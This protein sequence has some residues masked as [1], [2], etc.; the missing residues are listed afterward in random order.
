MSAAKPFSAESTRREFLKTGTL[1]GASLV[2][3]FHL[4]ARIAQ[5]ATGANGK[6]SARGDF[7][8]NAFIE[9]KPS[10]E[11]SLTVA[12]S[13]MGQGVRTSLAMILA[14]ELDAD[15]ARVTVK[16]AD[17]DTKY[18]DMTTGG[19]ASVRSSWDPLRK[20]GATA[21]DMLLTAAAETWK[22]P[23]AD[24]TTDGHGFIEHQKTNQR[25]EYRAFV[26]QA[27]ALPVPK[28]PPLKDPKD[29]RI[30]GKRTNRVDG[31]HIVIGEAHYG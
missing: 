7:Q 27:A 15:W 24:C 2:I 19:S 30:V 28:D 22:V 3:G 17:F 20:A 1:A 12:R 21:R 9:I 26:A 23:K 10:G 16:Q 6:D 29:Y 31:A 11:I 25:A 18:G 13:E 8:P 4:P 5:A 14:E